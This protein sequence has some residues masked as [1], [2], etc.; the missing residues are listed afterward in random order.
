MET[1]SKAMPRMSSNSQILR[2]S[3]QSSAAPR[4]ALRNTDYGT[5]EIVFLAVQLPYRNEYC[6]GLILVHQEEPGSIFIDL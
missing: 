5:R 1:E 4:T 3:K 2:F 6:S